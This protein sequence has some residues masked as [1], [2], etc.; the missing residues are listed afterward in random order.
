MTMDG[1][2]RLASDVVAIDAE[3]YLPTVPGFTV[4]ARSKDGKIGGFTFWRRT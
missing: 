2:E 4:A 3:R 1:F